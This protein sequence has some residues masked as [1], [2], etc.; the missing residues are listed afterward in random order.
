VESQRGDERRDKQFEKPTR[1]TFDEYQ[2]ANKSAP[3]NMLE[4]PVESRKRRR[5]ENRK[6]HLDS[7]IESGLRGRVISPGGS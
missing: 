5:E 1:L 3:A 4:L 6:D 2:K 7:G